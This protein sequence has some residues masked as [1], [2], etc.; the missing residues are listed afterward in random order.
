MLYT[1][2]IRA[3]AITAI[4]LVAIIMVMG[5]VAPAMAGNHG[6]VPKDNPPCDALD[7]PVSSNDDDKADPGKARAAEKICD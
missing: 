5:A 6:T 4:V 2:A 7:D 1:M 3:L